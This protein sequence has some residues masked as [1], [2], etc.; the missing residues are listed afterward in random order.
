MKTADRVKVTT[1]VEVPP[2][3]AFDVFTTEVDLWWRHGPKYRTSGA[4]DRKGALR[5]E[6]GASGR[7]VEAFEDGE[8]F[9]IGRVL[10]WEPA[11]RL[12]LEW[13]ARNFARDE[14]TEVE[15]R[16]EPAR[17]GTRVTI[18]HSG[19]AAIREDHPAR[20]GYTGGAFIAMIGHWWG[21]LATSLRV[22]AA[23][24]GG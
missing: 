13:R 17:G 24:R 23:K 3:L 10:S 6:P 7:L 14:R 22:H 20:H 16:F 9:E 15:V 11:E 19:W 2:E 8:V 1:F 21:E 4:S 18:E 12:V 5:F